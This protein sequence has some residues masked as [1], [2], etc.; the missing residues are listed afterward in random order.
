MVGTLQIIGITSFGSNGNMANPY[1]LGLPPGIRFQ[2]GNNSDFGDNAVDTN[3]NAYMAFIQGVENQAYGAVLDMRDQ[4]VGA[5]STVAGVAF[6]QDPLTISVFRA[7]AAGVPQPR[8]A[9]RQSRPGYPGHR[10][11]PAAVQ[12]HL[13]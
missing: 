1:W 4:V 10:R 9:C 7:N 2:I 5:G 3:A 13:F 6:P 12:R 8:R 11:C